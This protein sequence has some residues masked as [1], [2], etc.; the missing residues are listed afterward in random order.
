M[1]GP[2]RNQKGLALITIILVTL[3]LTVLGYAG[4]LNSLIGFKISNNYKFTAGA[5]QNAQAGISDA[6][7][8]LVNGTIA[9]S[10]YPPGTAT[11]TYPS[12]G[13]ASTTG[14]NNSYTVSYLLANGAIVLGSNGYPYYQIYSTGYFPATGNGIQRTIRV[15]VQLNQQKPFG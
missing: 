13:T 8:K 5:L 15:L 11:W 4:L 14:F 10:T 9:D 12:S 2:I 1:F 7:R 3:M 6:A